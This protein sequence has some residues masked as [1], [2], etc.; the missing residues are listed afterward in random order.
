MAPGTQWGGGR[1][2]VE[3][4]LDAGRMSVLYVA[5]DT[6]LQRVVVLKILDPVES[7][8][9]G[10]D[11]A[12]IDKARLAARIDHERIV[13]V[14]EV[15][16]HDG[17]P[18]VVMEY[19]PGNTLLQRMEAERRMAWPRVV[20]IATQIA[21]GLAVLHRAGIVHGDLNLKNVMVTAQGGIKLLGFGLARAFHE[22]AGTAGAPQLPDA[23]EPT[24][25]LGTI[26]TPG[27]MAPEQYRGLPS[28]ARADVF[29]LGV[30]AYALLTGHSP[31]PGETLHEVIDATQNG[32]PPMRGRS[33]RKVPKWLRDHIGQMLAVDP[34][35]RF[36][37]GEKVLAALHESASAMGKTVLL[38]G[39]IA[40]GVTSALPVAQ[41]SLPTNV[42]VIFAL[43]LLA[44]VAIL[45]LAT[46]AAFIGPLLI[47]AVMVVLGERIAAEATEG[48]SPE[49]GDGYDT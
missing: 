43:F 20:D 14:F 24:T 48:S 45:W 9:Q 22:A 4:T 47:S 28:D 49:D 21:E 38:R 15:G 37:D 19:V 18:F 5:T 41:I 34:R 2:T 6:V 13:R 1:Y 29:A 40:R 3:A 39:T 17:V 16:V 44:T 11:F 32:A 30:L 46:Q 12:L 42:N 23:S 31:F 26:G 8:N 33:W 25:T 7:P 36:A 35:L 10:S 27:Y